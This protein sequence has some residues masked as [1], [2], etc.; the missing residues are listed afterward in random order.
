MTVS[1]RTAGT[2]AALLWLL[3]SVGLISMA[4]TA[5]KWLV[6]GGALANTLGWGV[7]ICALRCPTCYRPVHLRRLGKT[8]VPITEYYSGSDVWSLFMADQCQACG[9]DLRRVAL[10]RR[11]FRL[12]RNRPSETRRA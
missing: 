2:V 3:T 7:F 11:T 6:L 4:G 5:S 10:S 8:A 12:S 1:L 9:T